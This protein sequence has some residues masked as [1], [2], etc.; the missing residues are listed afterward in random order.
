MHEFALVRVCSSLLVKWAQLIYGNNPHF[1]DDSDER[2]F[3]EKALIIT[4]I[5]SRARQIG[6][7]RERFNA[8]AFVY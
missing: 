6:H 7:Q 1:E 5:F 3:L 4:N 8:F 2:A